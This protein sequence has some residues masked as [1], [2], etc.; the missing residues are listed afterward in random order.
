M[1]L[2]LAAYLQCLPVS[3]RAMPLRGLMMLVECLDF[4]QADDRLLPFLLKC[5]HK[6]YRKNNRYVTW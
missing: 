4:P 1:I 5:N 2:N 6:E 3:E